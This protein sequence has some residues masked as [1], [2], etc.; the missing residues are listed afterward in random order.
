MPTRRGISFSPRGDRDQRRSMDEV[1]AELDR[2]R[3]G[4]TSPGVVIRIG[5]GGGGGGSPAPSGIQPFAGSVIQV[6]LYD[7]DDPGSPGTLI[8]ETTTDSA[9]YWELDVASYCWDNGFSTP[10][11]VT[12]KRDG[13][14]I[15]EQNVVD[16][17]I[18]NPGGDG[19]LPMIVSNRE[20]H[21]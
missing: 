21:V 6:Y 9:G 15:R 8:G 2:V 1:A 14:V 11:P 16:S 20:L 4:S 12:I 13:L 19:F 17:Y 7:P 3:G 18:V 5:G 10:F